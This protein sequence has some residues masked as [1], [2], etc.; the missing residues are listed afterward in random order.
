MKYGAAFQFSL[1]S[2]P[3]NRR[4]RLSSSVDLLKLEQ[5][6]VNLKR[7]EMRFKPQTS[8]GNLHLMGLGP[9]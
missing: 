7:S 4:G 6:S 2:S 3:S 5:E 1:F 8:E 9:I